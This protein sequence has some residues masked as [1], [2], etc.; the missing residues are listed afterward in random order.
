MQE[1]LRLIKCEFKKIKRKNF[2]SFVIFASLLFPIPLTALAIKGGFGNIESFDKLFGA[3]ISYG[4]AIMLPCVLGIMAAMLFIMERDNDTLKNL[5]VIPVSMNSIVTAKIALLFAM[6]ILFSL[7]TTLSAIVGGV[8][9]GGEITGIPVKFGVAALTGILYT[10]GTLPVLILIVLFNKSYIFSIIITVFY[11]FF[12]F[13]LAFVGLA[14]DSPIMN[15]LKSVMPTPTI[16]R[17]QASVFVDSG[18]SYYEIISPYFLP[19]TET[20]F[21]VG[22]LGILSY[23]VIVK[24]YK[25]RE[26]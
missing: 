14:I 9:S 19:L 17:W 1:L 25:M 20:V 22:I 26:G 15:V 24:I 23:W 8:I 4:E 13:F 21:V 2:I 5:R 16:Y 7:T 12:N 11:T 18:E 3:L 10:S 6:G